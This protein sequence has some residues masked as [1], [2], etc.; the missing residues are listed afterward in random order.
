MSIT[1]PSQPP[2]TTCKKSAAFIPL[3]AKK[4]TP[5]PGGPGGN[6]PKEKS[7]DDKP[8]PRPFDAYWFGFYAGPVGIEQINACDCN[9]WV[10]EFGKWI[11]DHG[12]FHYELYPHRF[13]IG[14]KDPGTL[15]RIDI[16]R[17][18]FFQ[19]QKQFEFLTEKY[20]LCLS[21]SL[22]YSRQLSGKPLESHPEF[23]HMNH[24]RTGDSVG[25]PFRHRLP[26]RQRKKRLRS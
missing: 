23:Y 7:G 11:Q 21:G 2:G 3:N 14:K 12:F 17:R 1:M 24:V 10:D 8:D 9:G 15:K 16:S 19:I 25:R 5:S 20:G 13:I 18:E 22:T 6:P 26:Q 4:R